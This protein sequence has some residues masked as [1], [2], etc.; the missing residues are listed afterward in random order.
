M[1]KILKGTIQ[2]S[3]SGHLDLKTDTLPVELS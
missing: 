1:I 2:E 3:N